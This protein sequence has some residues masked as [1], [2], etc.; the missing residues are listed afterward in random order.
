MMHTKQATTPPGPATRHPT[1]APD[2]A[3]RRRRA[4]EAARRAPGRI[5]ALIVSDPHDIRYLT[6][7]HEGIFWLAL[8]DRSP[9]GI[10]RHMLLDEVQASAPDCEI[11]L[12]TERS[13]ERP[14]M[15]LFL[16]TEL[17]RRMVARRSL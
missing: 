10:S 16:I 13:T 4:L 17:T 6:G 3:E 5:D 7:V 1:P 14:Q 9:F 15:E 12:P 8:S 11:L 2:F